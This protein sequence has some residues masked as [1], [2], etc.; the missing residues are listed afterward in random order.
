LNPSDTQTQWHGIALVII[1]AFCFSLAIPF[2][3]WTDGLDIGA[4]AFWRAIFGFLFLA[5]LVTHWREPL[6]FAAYR[7]SRRA[8]IALSMFVSLTVLFYTYAVQHTTAANAALLVNSAPV[9]VAVLAPFILKES[10]ARHTWISLGLALAGMIL[11]SDPARLDV[12]SGELGG[13]IAAA[14]SGLTYGG[15]MLISRSLRGRV[16]GLTQNLWSNGILALILLPWA[17]QA[18]ARATLDNLPVLIPLGVFSLGMSYLLY[19]LGLARARAQVVSMASL[20][21]PIFG[22]VMGLVFFAEV[23]PVTGWIGGALILSSIAL[24]SR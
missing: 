22:V 10:R 6:Q 24:I 4:I 2:I 12:E 17:L 3:R 8:L 19:F 16:T 20:S 13:I 21:E 7:E 9:Y 14:L 5:S 1:G 18:P 23:P 15:V 11:V